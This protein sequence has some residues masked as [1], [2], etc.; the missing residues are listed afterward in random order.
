[1]RHVII[2]ISPSHK[3][4]QPV[5]DYPDTMPEIVNEDLY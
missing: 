1:M 5:V 2:C 4:R 3:L